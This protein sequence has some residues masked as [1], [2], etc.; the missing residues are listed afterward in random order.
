[1]H[2]VEMTQSSNVPSISGIDFLF[3]M[4]KCI[5]V[6]NPFNFLVLNNNEKFDLTFTVS[7]QKTYY[8]Y[9]KYHVEHSHNLL[10]HRVIHVEEQ[11]MRKNWEN[12]QHF[13][14]RDSW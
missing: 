7:G 9:V 6:G 8:V 11:V 2:T 13:N 4:R 1:M 14:L 10:K 3:P 5:T 12:L